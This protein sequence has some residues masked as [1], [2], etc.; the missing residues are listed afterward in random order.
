MD[1]N[2]INKSNSCINCIQVAVDNLVYSA[3]KLYSYAVP[4]FLSN[5]IKVGMRV[6]VPFGRS[7][8]LTPGIVIGTGLTQDC[9][10]FK[11]VTEVID[12]VPLVTEKMIKLANFMKQK[13]FCT[14]YDALKLMIPSGM[15]MKAVHTYILNDKLC[16]NDFILSDKETDIINV[17][18]ENTD[19]IEEEKIAK[20]FKFSV[21]SVLRELVSKNILKRSVVFKQKTSDITQKMVKLSVTDLNNIKFTAKQ[22]I[23]IKFLKSHPE[24]ICIKELVYHTGVSPGVI[25][26]LE[27]KG[28]LKYSIEQIYREPYKN[29]TVQDS[30][31]NVM[32][33]EAQTRIFNSILEKYNQCRYHISLL[34]GITGSG[35][36]SVFMKLIDFVYNDGKGII[37]MVPEIALTPQIIS[38]FKVRFGNKVAVFHSGLSNGERMDEFKRVQN[39]DATIVIGTRSAVFAPVKNLGLIVM[40]EEHEYSYKSDSTPRYHARDIAKYRCFENS[41]LL[42]LS[43]AT[44]S[45]ES[46]YFAKREKYSLNMLTSRY[47]DAVLPA[48]EII[49]MN[50]EVEIGNM[51]PFSSALLDR[52]KYT[53]QNNKQAILLLNRRGFN[54]HVSCRNCGEVVTCPNCSIPLT[55]H[56]ANNRMMCHYCGHSMSINDKCPSCR[57][58]QLK[59]SGMGTQKIEQE[60]KTLV[61][62]VKILRM[63]ADTTQAKSSHEK[64]L[65]EFS[66]GKY[67]IMIGTQMV[68][69]GLD[70]PNVTLVGILS[71]DQSLYSDDFRSFE[72]TFSLLT[73]VIGRAGRAKNPGIAVIQTFTPENHIINLAAKQDYEQFYREE[74]EI[75]KAMLYPPFANICVV[76]F[77]GVNEFKVK[78]SA[79]AFFEEFKSL[80]KKEYSK[81]ALKVLGPSP[82]SILKLNNKYRYKIIIKYKDEKS[83]RKLLS[84]IILSCGIEKILSGTKLFIDINPDTIM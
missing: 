4:D 36:T 17:F 60:L 6:M 5:E 83:L 69:K 51:G 54:T 53:I 19:P 15:N 1:E 42:L 50:K 56:A 66:D 76:G 55:Y 27:K 25:H 82:A 80:T 52:I 9:S 59:Y 43:S 47:G 34:Y 16:L 62:D 18:L 12:K 11:L 22:K 45:L 79:K 70:F 30:S 33:N 49:D 14:L 67:D 28:I 10:N 39:G 35:K 74:I 63:D 23:V 40:D 31:C 77:T 78:R 41:A 48:V 71:A 38:T 81:L 64:K 37:L 58:H 13:Y 26:T 24:G 72:R 61:R 3:D 68:A 46:F 65:K 84:Q 2:F 20:K 75:R 57:E 21:V 44:P 73:Q 32:L 8:K 7:N 29:Y